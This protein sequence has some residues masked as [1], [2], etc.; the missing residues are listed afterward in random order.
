VQVE[1][2]H[3]KRAVTVTTK[4]TAPGGR[5][6]EKVGL[7]YDPDLFDHMVSHGVVVEVTSRAL[8]CLLLDSSACPACRSSSACRCQPLMSFS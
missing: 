8:Q 4:D 1:F 7:P 2:T 6:T 3:D 5:R